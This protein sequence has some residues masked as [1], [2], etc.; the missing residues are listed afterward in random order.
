[1]SAILSG[2]GSSLPGQVLTNDHFAYLDTTDE[3]ITKR[4]GIHERRWIGEGESLA[5]LATQAAE[6]ALKQ[7]GLCGSD[8]QRVIVATST[9]D[10]LAPGLSVEVA[11]RIGANFPAAFDIAASCAGFLCA[12]DQAVAAIETDRA[13][14]VL[15]C[16]ADALSRITDKTD[17]GTVVLLGDGAGAVVVSK[18]PGELR[19]TF[20]LAADGSKMDLLYVGWADRLLRMQG[21]DIF[22]SAVQAMADHSR[23][24]LERSGLTAENVD[25]FVP[26]QA[27]IRIIRAVARELDL[28]ADK[29]FVNIEKVANT[30]A[31]SI[32][33]AL[34]Q[35]AADNVLLP[36]YVLGL[37]A[38][39][40]GLTWGAGLITWKP[41]KG[42]EL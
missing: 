8:V 18:A 30:S 34:A 22:D 19:P 13:E 27:N 2:A 20:A 40:A 7:A 4:T 14:H 39:G 31:A 16:G 10:R 35:A 5:G 11:D 24:V 17:R 25:L 37:A 21:R 42:A 33:I 32:P 29:V 9:G 28:P 1:M 23:L 15:V 36:G 12:L 6:D 41:T 3:W 38:F 26:H